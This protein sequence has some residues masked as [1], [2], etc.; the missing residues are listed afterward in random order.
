MDS[1]ASLPS[2]SDIW[3][4]APGQHRRRGDENGR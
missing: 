4:L 3:N 1:A 2:F